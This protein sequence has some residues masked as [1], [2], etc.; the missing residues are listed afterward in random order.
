MLSP[1]MGNM[2]DT[3]LPQQQQ[4][5]IQQMQQIQ[6]PPP[7]SGRGGG[8]G[9]GGCGGGG[10]GATR[11]MTPPIGGVSRGATGAMTPPTE[12]EEDEEVNWFIKPDYLSLPDGHLRVER[13][14]T[15]G[16]PAR[17]SLADKDFSESSTESEE[18][19]E[20]VRSEKTC[21]LANFQQVFR[22]RNDLLID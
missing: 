6:M 18:E 2:P 4:H 13:L 20:V 14:G 10:G 9:G 19:E 16:T 3:G 1:D 7:R 15:A 11:A 12:S 8:G 22:G 5:Q 17:S 21:Q